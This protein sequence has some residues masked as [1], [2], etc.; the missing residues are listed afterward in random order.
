MGTHS[1]C[2]PVR[3]LPPALYTGLHPPHAPTPTLHPL[4]GAKNLYIIAVSR[5]GSRLNRLPVAGV[6]SYVLATVKKGKPELRKKVHPAIVIRQ[7]K[8]WRRR[9][10]IFIYFGASAEC[11]AACSGGITGARVC[12]VR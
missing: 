10:G 6:G 7:R 12:A 9:D 1:C 3:A 8:A 5:T 11:A 4:A 2:E